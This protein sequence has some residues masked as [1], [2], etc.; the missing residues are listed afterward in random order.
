MPH[1]MHPILNNLSFP[2]FDE[3]PSVRQCTMLPNMRKITKK[4]WDTMLHPEG[5]WAVVLFL[6]ERAC[7]D[8]DEYSIPDHVAC[9][10]AYTAYRREEFPATATLAHF[11]KRI[12]GGPCY[13][14]FEGLKHLRREGGVDVY[15]ML[16]GT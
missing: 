3:E 1:K 13:G 8:E 16:W 12:A 7:K 9:C 10:S 5:A 2:M 4:E 6:D 15:Q 11:V 14:I